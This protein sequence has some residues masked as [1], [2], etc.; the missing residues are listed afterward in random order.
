[1]VVL[2]ML[3]ANL[4]ELRRN[5]LRFPRSAAAQ[6][7]GIAE[8]RLAQ[9]ESGIA[10]TVFEAEQLADTY[11]IDSDVL[12]EQ[13][14]EV[15]PTDTVYTLALLDEF[16]E[17]SAQTKHAIIEAAAAARDLMQMRHLLGEENAWLAFQQMPRLS[18]AKDTDEPHAQGRYYSIEA[19]N[20]LALHL[21][22]IP[23][24]RDMVTAWLP[25][26]T[27]L[28][29]DLHND[30][31][32]GITFADSLR[33]PTIILNAAGKNINPVVRRF[34]LAHELCHLLVDSNR[35][36][37]LALLSGFLSEGALAVERRANAFA[38]RLIAP[39]MAITQAL[40][41]ASD[42]RDAALSLIK[43]YGLPYQAVRLAFYYLK[44]VAI[45][46]LP[47]ASFVA[48]QTDSRWHEAED[49]E[50]LSHFPL[51]TVPLARRSH[52]ARAA[53]QL[54]ANGVI[55]RDRFARMLGVTPVEDIERVVAYFGFDPPAA[56]RYEC[57]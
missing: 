42:P 2:D 32:A 45:D 19:R 16:Q 10:P 15:D 29:A 22:P 30:G 25:M 57:T 44:G 5:L 52:I 9:L 53:T 33:G 28:Y 40:K 3:Y 49:P 18:H 8:E 6:I 20:C 37:P 41:R 1:M 26:V 55:G 34:S 27:V 39:E 46:P 56:Q 4:G 17:V 23:S 21:Q 54:Y 38:T 36:Q 48:A 43:Q 14:I 50:G 47:G 12:S 51:S 31:L 7:A 24:I 35:M 11:G 13:P